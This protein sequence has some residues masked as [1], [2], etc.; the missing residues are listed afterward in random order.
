MD[1]RSWASFPDSPQTPVSAPKGSPR[2]SQAFAPPAPPTSSLGTCPRL[3]AARPDFPW[4]PQS[5]CLP[6]APLPVISGYMGEGLRLPLCGS[7]LTL[8]AQSGVL[9]CCLGVLGGSVEPAWAQRGQAL[10]CRPGRGECRGPCP[11]PSAKSLALPTGP[12]EGALLLGGDWATGSV[13]QTQ[14]IY[15]EP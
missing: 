8:P 9:P 13:L 12:Q 1:F 11:A 15:R 10:P 6:K 4:A 14:W 7:V 3:Q 2:S 5:K